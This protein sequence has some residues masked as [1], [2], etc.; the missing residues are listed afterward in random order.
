M[1]N[2]WPR[3]SL[4]G[5]HR[6]SSRSVIAKR[7]GHDNQGQRVFGRG[8][9]PRVDNSDHRGQRVYEGSALAVLYVTLHIMLKF[10]CLFKIL[11]NVNPIIVLD[12]SLFIYK[13][14][15]Y[16]KHM[17]MLILC[18]HIT[19]QDWD[20]EQSIAF[21]NIVKI[22]PA[23]HSEILKIFLGLIG[24]QVCKKV[25]VFSFSISWRRIA[26]WSIEMDN[27]TI[28]NHDHL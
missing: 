2:R 19:W 18:R 8:V 12:W 13:C 7:E 28:V 25:I 21:D 27:S 24:K 9:R 6:E 3:W 11:V 20:L 22:P 23:K 5:D 10:K 14:V 4:A 17:G 1:K 16:R 15:P 26:L